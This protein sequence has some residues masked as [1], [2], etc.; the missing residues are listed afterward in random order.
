MPYKNKTNRGYLYIRAY[1]PYIKGVVGRDIKLTFK[2]KIQILFSKGIAVCLG[3]VFKEEG[4][5]DA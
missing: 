2:Q 5:K 1:N 3:N 4:E